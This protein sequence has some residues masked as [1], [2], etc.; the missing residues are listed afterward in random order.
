[1]KKFYGLLSSDEGV[2][3]YVEFDTEAEARAYA[4]GVERTLDEA[5]AG[6]DQI[7]RDFYRGLWSEIEPV[8]EF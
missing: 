6:D 8:S 7:A 4:K 2:I 3:D 5:D 1:M